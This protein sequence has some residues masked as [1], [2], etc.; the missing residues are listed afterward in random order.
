MKGVG[1]NPKHEGKKKGGLKVH[2]MIDA[3]SD[4]PEFVK[5]SEA[6]LPTKK[7]NPC[8]WPFGINLVSELD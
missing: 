3:H 8:G 2:M 5:I 7:A 6:K 1:I 4:T